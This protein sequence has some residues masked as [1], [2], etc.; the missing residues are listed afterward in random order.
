MKLISLVLATVVWFMIN[1]AMTNDL[2][3]IQYPRSAETRTFYGLPITVITSAADGRLFKILPQEVNVT[4]RASSPVVNLQLLT[5]NDIEAFVN[6]TGLRQDNAIV[7]V[8]VFR[9]NG[10]A[11]VEIVPTAVDVRRIQAADLLESSQTNAP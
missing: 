3:G 6:L 2:A 9:P 10:V 4:V 8:K 7:P 1:L 11:V 5:A